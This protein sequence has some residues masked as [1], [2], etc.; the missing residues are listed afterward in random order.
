MSALVFGPAQ[1]DFWDDPRGY[2]ELLDST[3]RNPWDVITFSG[4][5]TPGIAVVTGHKG[6][7]VDAKKEPGKDG[8]VITHQG[9][10]PSQVDVLVRMWHPSHWQQMQ[11]MVELLQPRKGKPTAHDVFHPALAAWGIHRLY[12]TEILLPREVPNTKGMKEVPIICQ[13][14]RPGTQDKTAT[15]QGPHQHI[16]DV[17]TNKS[18]KAAAQQPPS[19]QNAG[20]TG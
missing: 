14:W 6:G 17:P 11:Q 16:P 20:K 2:E 5:A 7:K 15:V 10:D 1:Q 19:A 3:K 18:I 9:Y 4:M 12:V 8:A 13:E